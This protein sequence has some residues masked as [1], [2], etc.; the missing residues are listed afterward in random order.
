MIN[1]EM[2]GLSQRDRYAGTAEHCSATLYTLLH[3]KTIHDKYRQSSYPCG[4]MNVVEMP[5]IEPGS[6]I[7]SGQSRAVF[8]TGPFTTCTHSVDAVAS[9]YVE[10]MIKK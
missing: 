10:K 5:G 7:S 9:P 2:P 8:V 6:G 4:G 3:K 1:V